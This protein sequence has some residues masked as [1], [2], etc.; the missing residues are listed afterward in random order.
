MHCS[1]TSCLPEQLSQHKL[2]KLFSA[3]DLT[4]SPLALVNPMTVQ[5]C[6]VGVPQED[7]RASLGTL[8]SD[9]G[10]FVHA[11]QTLTTTT[12]ADSF[13][14]SLVLIQ[15]TSYAFCAQVVTS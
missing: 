12:V 14:L 2:P 13:D 6:S 1:E 8:L 10:Q 11:E 9:L 7:Q 4:L 15:N 3:S 5:R